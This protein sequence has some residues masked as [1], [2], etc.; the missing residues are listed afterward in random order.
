MTLFWHFDDV[1]GMKGQASN[2][3]NG[4]SEAVYSNQHM[5]WGT[6]DLTKLTK[7]YQ[8]GTSKLNRACVRQDQF[9]HCRCR[10]YSVTQTQCAKAGLMIFQLCSSG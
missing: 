3:F 10:M 6:G 2:Y 1:C 5:N 7:V 8:T 9:H 4:S